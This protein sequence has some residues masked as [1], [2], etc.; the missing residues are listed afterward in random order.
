[1]FRINNRNRTLLEESNSNDIIFAIVT[2][3]VANVRKLIN[4]RKDIDR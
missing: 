1:M 4:I 2:N 3:N